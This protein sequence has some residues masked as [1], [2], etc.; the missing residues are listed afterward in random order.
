MSSHKLISIWL[1]VLCLCLTDCSQEISRNTS[2]FEN[3]K[4]YNLA[5]AVE[6]GDT[7]TIEKLVKN[8]ST[9][10]NFTNPITGSNVLVLCLYIEQF[11]SFKKLLELGANPNFINPFTKRSVL[12]EAIRPFGNQFE[13]R[14]EHQYLELLLNYGADANYAIANDFKIDKPGVKGLIMS[15]S[16][17]IKAS[18]L[19]LDAVKFLMKSGADPYMK[20]GSKQI[21]PFSEAVES[22]K[23][24]II[25]YYI[26][27]LKVDIHQPMSIVKR[28]SNNEEVTYYIQDYITNKFTR[29]KLF[30]DKAEI[31]RLKKQSQDIEEANEELWNL[32]Q[33][34]ESMGVDFKSYE[35]Q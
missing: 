26:D 1:F 2:F 15:T 22:G 24:D 35:Y 34:L 9:L 33:K 5:K 30:N 10:L 32:I 28:K 20:V 27:S 14:K 17:L 7:T 29:A 8:D 25:N 16:P 6:K 11:E 21:T 23:I 19:D 12:I 31:E 3:T 18:S 13:W 4:A